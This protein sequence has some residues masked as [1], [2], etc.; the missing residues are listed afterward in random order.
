[1][2]AKT[3][4]HIWDIDI[5]AAQRMVLLAMVDHADHDGEHINA[6][7]RYIAWK[8]GYSARNTARI[9][10]TLIKAGLLIVTKQGLGEASE[11]K[12]DLSHVKLKR[13]YVGRKPKKPKVTHDKMSSVKKQTH[14]K[15]SSVTHE[16]G[17]THAKMS[18]GTH[19]KMAID[20]D[21]YHIE[22]DHVPPPPTNPQ[23]A[24][25]GGEFDLEIARLFVSYNIK[26][27]EPLA[28]L[29]RD[30]FPDVTLEQLRDLCERLHEPSAGDYAGSRLY[31]LLKHGPP[32]VPPPVAASAPDRPPAPTLRP[33]VPASQLREWRDKYEKE[34]SA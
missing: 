9:V 30:A 20:H 16:N 18:G 21:Q 17:T 3:T 14:D 31:R 33:G 12:F 24:G 11:Y 13:L 10:D 1:M 23:S 29:Y 15:M 27:A 5:P 6:P 2:S 28:R 22:S 34:H 26:Q 8:T 25:G 19:D 32:L 4:G 7:I